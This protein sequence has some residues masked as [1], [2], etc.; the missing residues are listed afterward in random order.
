M[1]LQERTNV[2]VVSYEDPRQRKVRRGSPSEGKTVDNRPPI[3]VEDEPSVIEG[4]EYL[5]FTGE[6]R[7][8]FK[9]YS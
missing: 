4:V 3:E 2:Y 6:R 7:R 1:F 5:S 8:L 9:K